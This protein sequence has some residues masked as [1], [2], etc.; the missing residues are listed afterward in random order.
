MIPII[1]ETY[2]SKHWGKVL[3]IYDSAASSSI[4]VM[5]LLVTFGLHLLAWRTL[6]LV[7]AAALLLLPMGFWKVAIEPKQTPASQ[8]PRTF[9]LL[10]RRS[11]WVVGLLWVAASASY[12]GLFS[13]LPLFLIKNVAALRLCQHPDRYFKSWWP[14]RQ[15]RLRI[16]RG[17]L[18]L[19]GDPHFQPPE[20]RAKHHRPCPCSQPY[21]LNNC[22]DPPGDSLQMSPPI[23]FSSRPR[24]QSLT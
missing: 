4:F 7:L 6:L 23:S 18:W 24:S 15:H 8:R 10:K 21:D 14:L 5:P 19:A 17:P 12:S 2:D 11:I 9:N 22:S 13:I 20:H 1:A 16:S 3:G